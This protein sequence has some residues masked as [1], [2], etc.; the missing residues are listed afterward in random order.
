MNSPDAIM[1]TAKRISGFEQVSQGVGVGSYSPVKVDK[2]RGGG[3][4][5]KGERQFKFPDGKNNNKRSVK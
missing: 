5:G 2:I 3:S 1:G 4:F